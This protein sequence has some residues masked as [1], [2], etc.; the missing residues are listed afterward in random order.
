MISALLSAFLNNLL[1]T[2]SV[3]FAPRHA[4]KDNPFFSALK[5]ISNYK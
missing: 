4:K 3:F 2:L 1:N 5:G